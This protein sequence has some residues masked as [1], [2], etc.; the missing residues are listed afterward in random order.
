MDI[1]TAFLNLQKKISVKNV[2]TDCQ[3]LV[4]IARILKEKVLKKYAN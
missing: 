4:I 3:T 2:W 1:L